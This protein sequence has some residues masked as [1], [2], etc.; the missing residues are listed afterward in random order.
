MVS[1]LNATPYAT[2]LTN[3]AGVVS[4]RLN[5]PADNV[6]VIGNGG[7]LTNDLGALGRGLIVTN[8]T[9]SGMTGGVF[10]V[11]VSKVGDC[12]VRTNS[13]AIA[14]NAPR[15]LAINKRPGSPYFGRVYVANA[16]T[17]TAGGPGD[18]IFIFNSDLSSTFG[19]GNTPRNAGLDFI[20]GDTTAKPYRIAVGVDDD[21]L[22]ICDWSDYSGN[23]YVTDPDVT[24]SGYALQPLSAPGAAVRPVTTANNH[25]SIAAVVVTGVEGAN[26][27]IYTVD[28]DLTTDRDLTLTEMN[29]LWKY[30]VGSDPLPTSL[31]DPTNKLVTPVVAFTSQTMNLTRGPNGYL[32]MTQY[33]S[34]GNEPGVYIV[35][36]DSGLITTSLALSQ[37]LGDTVDRLRGIAGVAVS[38][39]GLFL[40]AIRIEANVPLLHIVPLTNGI[41]DLTRI[42][43]FTALGTAVGRSCEFDAAG[44]LY[45][46]TDTG[47]VRSLTLGVSSVA[48]TGSDGTFSLVTPPL[49]SVVATQ[50]TASESGPTPGTFTFTR[51][52]DTTAPLTV[53]FTI[54]GSA[55]NGVDYAAISSSITFAAGESSTNLTIIPVDDAISEANETVTLSIICSASYSSVVGSSATVT[56]IDNDPPIINITTVASNMYERVSNDYVTFR[57]TRSGDIA[58]TDVTVYLG[59][60]GTA[61]N[62]VD[63]TTAPGSVYFGFGVGTNDITLNPIDDSDVEGTET[64]V[65]TILPDMAYVV[66]SPSSA[67]A[68]LPDDDYG[69]EII[70]FSDNFETDTTANWIVRWAAANNVL[71]YHAVWNYDYSAKSIPA[72]PGSATTRGLITTVNKRD[73]TASA[74]GVNLY[75][76]GQNFSGDYALRFRMYLEGVNG[77][78][79]TEHVIFGINHSGTRTNWATR[80]TT[81]TG[82]GTSA[83]GNGDGIWFNI[84]ADS[85]G[86]PGGGDWGAFVSTSWPPTVL[87][88]RTWTTLTEVFKTPVYRFA[89]TPASFLPSLRQTWVDV[90]VRQERGLI[91]LIVNGT[92]IFQ[93]TN[94]TAFTSGNIMLGYNDGFASI[95]GGTGNTGTDIASITSGFVVYDDVRVVKAGLPRITHTQIVGGN[96]QITFD[97]S[98]FGPFRLLE[99]TAVTGP[100]STNFSASL[101]TNAPGIFQFTAPYLG[102]SQR[103][104]RI[105]R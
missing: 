45:I 43:N 72:A 89:G 78:G 86:F 51:E 97:D 61:S 94:T 105:Q 34:V 102:G 52:G 13:P 10:Y 19:Q 38:P 93:F 55:S 91:T 66:G 2:D 57:V 65:A 60:S 59:W 83:P 69:A 7:T 21:R 24:T 8:L 30:P 47:G 53:N 1:Q 14:F 6:K 56:I 81:G 92:P 103:Y 27:T 68:F 16:T 26:L 37:A 58:N 50:P 44:N 84:V 25:G 32:Y 4:F 70:L 95:G 80:T 31:F 49:V 74:A 101:T 12:V 88:S 100:Y 40:A 90:E 87:A 54:G 77:A 18:G 28:E 96:V 5:E 104:F 48:T 73:T 46:I 76:V 35:D 11:V 33:R 62:G 3:A 42:L 41:P 64:I 15:G 82:F 23:L 63:Y 39:D 20:T 9:G 75:P 99:A 36:P 98:T 71:D 22:Y 67:T 79:T 29:S 17:N 85:S